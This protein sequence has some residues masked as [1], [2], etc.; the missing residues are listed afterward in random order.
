MEIKLWHFQS[1][2]Q[3]AYWLY[4]Y[5]LLHSWF[6]PSVS[7]E[8]KSCQASWFS[9]WHW[10]HYQATNPDNVAF[11]H[12]CMTALKSKELMDRSRVILL[13]QAMALR[14]GRI[15]LRTMKSQRSI[16]SD[17]MHGLTN[18]NLLPPGL[19]MKQQFANW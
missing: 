18:L 6:F 12:V 16:A 9:T 5:I 14:T 7:S 1:F 10:L 17:N 19:R 11:C 8:K 2:G 15:V 13:L 4:D 3:Q